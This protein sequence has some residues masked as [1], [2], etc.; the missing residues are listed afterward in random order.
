MKLI[1][2]RWN[3]YLKEQKD[4]DPVAKGVLF[5]GAKVL[6][7]KRAEKFV[8][9]TSPWEWDL[10][11][12][13]LE[14]SETPTQAL[15]RE[16]MEEVGLTLGSLTEVY[17][18]SKTTFFYCTEWK[19]KIELSHEHEEYKWVSPDDIKD[20]YIGVDYRTAVRKAIKQ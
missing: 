18:A 19:G 14:S 3:M 10:P 4:R 13:H 17:N 15:K 20:Y 9:E 5:D 12:G 16:A 8:K 7:L 2:E 1:M 6:I 11:G